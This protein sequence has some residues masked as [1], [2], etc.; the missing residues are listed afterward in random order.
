VLAVALHDSGKVTEACD[1]LE[2]LLKV[3]PANRNARLSLIQYYLENGQEPKA[4]VLLGWKK[5]NTGDPALK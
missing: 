5:M 2:R 3:Q 4:Q 1:E